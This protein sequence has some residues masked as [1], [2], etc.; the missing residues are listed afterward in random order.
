MAP[1]VHPLRS[2]ETTR[3]HA[4]T[5]CTPVAEL[6]LSPSFLPTLNG[7]LA[8]LARICICELLG[9][10]LNRAKSQCIRAASAGAS[11]CLLTRLTRLVNAGLVRRPRHLAVRPRRLSRKASAVERLRWLRLHN[12]WPSTEVKWS[13][14]A[15]TFP[16]D[17]TGRTAGRAR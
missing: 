7:R 17:L 3:K 4:A 14:V 13:C 12:G 8:S 6:S 11:K 16:P 5:I 1:L 15:S 9:A 10:S 2:L